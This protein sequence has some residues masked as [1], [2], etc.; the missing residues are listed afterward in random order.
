ME[1]SEGPN[2]TRYVCYCKDSCTKFESMLE[3]GECYSAGGK[4]VRN[5]ADCREEP[6]RSQALQV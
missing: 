2:Y 5:C 4:T 6:V 1:S 3:T